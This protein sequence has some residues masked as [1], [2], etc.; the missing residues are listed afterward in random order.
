[1]PE[2][3]VQTAQIRK[4]FRL[5]RYF[6]VSGLVGILIVTACLIG[7]YREITKRNLVEQQARSNVDMTRA[8][9]NHIW[10]NHREF[11]QGPSG[12]TAEQIKADPH[13][14]T[15]RDET[16]VI[17]KGVQIVK[18]KLYD[19]RG[20]TVFSTDERQVGED[21]RGN[22]AFQRALTGEVVSDITFRDRFDAAEGTLSNR[23]LIYSYIPIRTAPDASPEAVAE[24]YSDVTALLQHQQRA[25]WQI[26]VLVLVLLSGLYAF[27]FA[28]IRKADGIIHRQE[29]EREAKE[30]EIRHQA[31]HDA[32]TGLPNRMYFAE[33]L[34]EALR[35]AARKSQPAALMFI[36]LDRFK[37]V[38][39]SLGHHA[40][41]ML[42]KTVADH[43]RG[44][45][46]QADLL[47]RM[48][49]DE[50]TVILPELSAPEDAAPLAR[51]II[52]A[53]SAPVT[54]YEHEVTIGA[55]I[56]IAVY[57]GDGDNARDLLK[58][59]DAAMYAAKQAGR[60]THAYY[61]AEMNALARQRQ[62]LET[63]LQRAFRAGEFML[64][65]Q[66][67]LDAASRR[68]VA[69]EALL[70]WRS[71]RRGVVPAAEFIDVLE[72]SGLMPIVGE[73]VLRTACT[74][75]RRWAAE[76]RTELR[77]SINVSSRQFQSH[78]FVDTVQRVLKETGATPANIELELTESMLLTDAGHART[79]LEALRALGVRIAVEDFGTAY[80]SP[81]YLRRF[82][83]DSIKIHRSFTSDLSPAG[84]DRDVALAVVN[85]AKA[86]GLVVVAQCVESDA[87][88]DFFAGARCDELQG[89]YFAAAQSLEELEPLLG[90]VGGNAPREVALVA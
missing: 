85:L 60:G 3:A 23:N 6:L 67:R 77:V 69:V 52:T 43:V 9:A 56:G 4:H 72:D 1:M 61:R 24:V 30:A 59:A 58:N 68:V 79:A 40:G 16:L 78:R 70:R 7:L 21:K 14:R 73:W 75:Q 36:D 44:C 65:Y 15:L 80:S 87:Q 11:V 13:Y 62:G 32:L 27:L 46:R 12:R 10:Q 83:V 64:H 41:D 34:D 38:N 88:A 50:F 63:E 66:P 37:M 74:Q 42:L 54:L 49:G 86:L 2:I 22:T 26:V 35:I 19:S 53:V 71:A 76:G 57:P 45:L 51:R 82:A 81:S 5:T 29:Q 28:V 20:L 33:R 55:T 89:H 31:H 39:D 18:I 17:M 90:T 25:L 8:L 47:F 84:R 48:G